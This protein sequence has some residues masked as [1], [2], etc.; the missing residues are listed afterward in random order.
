VVRLHPVH[1]LLLFFL[2]SSLS[3]AK[4]FRLG[5][6]YDNPVVAKKY[7][8]L[9]N[10]IKANGLDTTIHKFT[11]YNH[12]IKAFSDHKL[13]AMISGSGVAGILILKDIAYPILRPLNVQGWST[14]RAVIISHKGSKKYNKRSA[15][16]NNKSVAATELASSG[17]FFI[18]SINNS[19]LTM[20]PVG[21]HL[22]ALRSLAR[23]VSDIAIIKN[24]VWDSVFLHYP[25]LEKVGEVL[26][27]NPNNPLMISRQTDLQAVN[28]IRAILQ[29]LEFDD[30]KLALQVKQQLQIEKYIVTTLDDFKYTIKLL[31]RAGVTKEYKFSR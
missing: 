3:E 16:F 23:G 26:G 31:Q 9:A 10:Y 14:Y 11:R 4:E 12:A 27:S 13:D 20:L 29:K 8:T 17:E 15:F 6:M 25:Q 1:L 7:Y 21:S 24:R 5:I 19:S 28:K 18:K 22:L 2:F 30:S